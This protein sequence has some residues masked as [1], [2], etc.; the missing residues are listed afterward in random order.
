MDDP[1]IEFDNF[2]FTNIPFNQFGDMNIPPYLATP[3]D[4]HN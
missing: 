3:N 1:L 4:D 2:N